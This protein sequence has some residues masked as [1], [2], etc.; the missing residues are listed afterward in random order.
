MKS[1]EFITEH[2]L[3]EDWKSA[4]ATG[5][6]AAATAFGGAGDA[7]AATKQHVQKTPAHHQVKKVDPKSTKVQPLVQ[8]KKVDP[9]TAYTV[10][11]QTAVKNGITNPDELAQFL[12]QCA[13]ETGNFKHLGE[14]GR[15]AK[16]VQKY[17]HSTGN[18]GQHDSLKYAGRGFI[19]LTGR[20]NYIDAGEDL[21]GDADKYLENPNL[22]ADVHE[23]AK[24]AVWFWNKNVK[25]QV[26]N[27]TDTAAVTR[28]INGRAAPQA[29][30]QKRHDI[31]AQYAPAVKK[32]A[33]GRG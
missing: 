15:P 23:A 28:A 30:I 20:G 18:R 3:D 32:W 33:S 26:K 29:E 10:L 12:A 22:A 7:E 14:I 6:L 17:K 8:V 27:F 24:I 9:H 13:A 16:L 4:L 2:E 21:H 1:S 11:W 19:Q 31:Y 5:A 25:R